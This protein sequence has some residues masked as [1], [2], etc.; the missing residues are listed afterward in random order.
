[1]AALILIGD[2]TLGLIVAKKAKASMVDEIMNNVVDIASCA[3]ASVDAEMLNEIQD[4]DEETE[5]YE[6]IVGQLAVFRD[7]ANIEYIY[8]V[9][10]EDG[11]YKYIV[12]SDTEEPA[13]IGEEFEESDGLISA[14]DG[15]ASAD[16]ESMVDEWG[17]HLSAY[18]PIY[19]NGEVVA[20]TG[21]DISMDWINNQVASINIMIAIACIII[22]G[23]SMVILLVLTGYLNESFKTLNNKILD[24]TDG[25]GDLTKRIEFKR[26]DEFEVLA[27]SMNTF[28]GEIRDLVSDV[29]ECAKTLSDS[30]DEINKTIEVNTTIVNTIDSSIEVISSNMEESSAAGDLASENLGNTAGRVNEFSS[31]V[32]DIQKEITEVNADAIRVAEEM[33]E[34][35]N[36]ATDEI[37]I[38]SSK[39]EEASDEAKAIEKV[40]EVAERI[41]SIAA[42]TRMLS[43]NAQIE[44]ARAGEMGRG[45]VVV[46]SEVGNL[47][48]EID[49]AISEITDINNHA[50]NAVNKLIEATKD[51]TKF[52]NESVLEDYKTF[53]EFGINYGET[54]NAIRMS[55]NRILAES[56][57]L[58]MA[59]SAI[60]ESVNE[61]S[62]TITDSATS[63]KDVVTESNNITT[64]MKELMQ[65]ADNN[66]QAAETLNARVGKYKF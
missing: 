52:I 45:F 48:I 40:R 32:S 20:I 10:I 50:L 57:E 36:K 25:N 34:H 4:G 11:T 62:V 51:M 14:F 31:N 3:A 38:L 13:D 19:L 26:G 33:E 1:M 58:A 9:R 46:A 17:E 29:A 54:T 24:L 44:A 43:L 27:D 65:M 53:T 18:A 8:T 60:N 37:A 41:A 7:N 15:T 61:M 2:V 66:T 21:I 55:M 64:S 6:T 12:D 56:E 28:I 63:A 16:S 39:M 59:I 35:K 49:G 5:E 42:Q 23:I 30:T 22:L 47:S